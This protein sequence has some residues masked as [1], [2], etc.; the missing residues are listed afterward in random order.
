VER[1]PGVEVRGTG[2]LTKCPIIIADAVTSRNKTTGFGG[3]QPP[4][5]LRSTAEALAMLMVR[6]QCSQF[7]SSV[8]S[9]NALDVEVRGA[10]WRLIA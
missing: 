3:L 9:G 1:A 10:A 7:H 4:S 8:V 5:P 2:W 6:Q